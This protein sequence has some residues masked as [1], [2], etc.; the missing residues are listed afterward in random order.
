MT[1]ERLPQVL[2]TVIWERDGGLYTGL[3][4][5]IREAFAD[6]LT[7]CSI[8]LVHTGD[9]RVLVRHEDWNR[10]A[11]ADHLWAV[12]GIRVSDDAVLPPDMPN[13]LDGDEG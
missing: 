11:L 10:E 4:C 7:T 12:Y 1:C 2:D 5:E 13:R 6:I 3:I 8:S 9:V